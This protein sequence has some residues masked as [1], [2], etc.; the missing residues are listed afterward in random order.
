MIGEVSM[1]VPAEAITTDDTAE[2]RQT[3]L[4]AAQDL[5]VCDPEIMGGIPTIRGPRIPVYAV[6]ALAAAGEPL[7]EILDMYPRLTKEK[8]ELA[9]VYAEAN[10]Q[11]DRPHRRVEIP[12]GATVVAS[13]TVPF[14]KT[15]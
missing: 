6:S 5:V 3:R 7:E 1:P 9:S 11:G 15:S 10:P 8:V 14:S 4:R 13:Y 2:A 12:A